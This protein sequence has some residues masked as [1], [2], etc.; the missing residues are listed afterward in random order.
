MRKIILLMACVIVSIYFVCNVNVV[1]AFDLVDDK[2]SINGYAESF[3]AMGLEKYDGHLVMFRNTLQL[4]NFIKLTDEATFTAIFRGHY[5]GSW[6]ADDGLPQ[7]PKYLD[8]M[9]D[10]PG[11]ETDA[12]FREYYLTYSPGDFIIKIGKQQ[13]VWG[14]ADILRLSDIINALDMSW[15]GFFESWEDL[16]RPVRMFNVVYDV[17]WRAA[18]YKIKLELIYNPEDFS[19]T[20]FA[21][22]GAFWA[23]PTLPPGSLDEMDREMPDKHDLRNGQVGGRVR[24]NL[25]GWDLAAFGYYSMMEGPVFKVNPFSTKGQTPV[26]FYWPRISTYGGSF[27]FYEDYTGTVF[28][29]EFTY[30]RH[31]S[32]NQI[33]V[34]PVFG[35]LPGIIR[36]NRV[37][38]MLGFDRPCMIESL[39]SQ[40]TF[41]VSGQLFQSFILNADSD[42]NLFNTGMGKKSNSRNQTALT[43][44][45]NT[46]YFDAKLVPQIQGGY[47]FAG[48][49]MFN[50]QI[51]Y[52]PNWSLQ[53]SAGVLWLWSKNS[54]YKY[55]TGIFGPFASNDQIYLR[56]RVLF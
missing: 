33:A 6:S 51:T 50:P 47:D 15:R 28:R 43:L 29:G 38:Y 3:P 37:A 35:P 4:E 1:R 34:H 19:P 5:E 27:N 10:G 11:M 26:D 16:R 14:E 40:R 55:T 18:E 2:W 41:F 9:P 46:E 24:M 17:P 56:A 32:F 25:G 30:T 8:A 13:L 44:L 22:E 45:V 52:K 21:P 39:N 23:I 54:P 36:K 12:T 7:A 31:Q 20:V 48:S 53:F 42:D 49:G